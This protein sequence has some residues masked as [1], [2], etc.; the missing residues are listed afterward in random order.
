M[1]KL[2]EAIDQK[3]LALFE[4]ALLAI[5]AA[6]RVHA[7]QAIPGNR[8]AKVWDLAEGRTVSIESL[9]P[10]AEEL[11]RYRGRNSMPMFNAMC[12][13]CWRSQTGEA[14]GYNDHFW[15][16]F[17]GP[18]Y[19]Q[20]NVI[21]G[22]ACFDYRALPKSAPKGWPKLKGHTFPIGTITFAK[23]ID[24]ARWATKETIIGHATWEDGRSRGVYFLMTRVSS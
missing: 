16:A 8:L 15:S 9:V 22:S 5:S 20:I 4:S 17:T 18:G 1:S 19:F 3:D 10:R 7:I 6:E 13:V 23:M 24:R 11:V 21:D 12:K 14:L 2:V